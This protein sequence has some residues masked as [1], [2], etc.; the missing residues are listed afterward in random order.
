MLLTTYVSFSIIEKLDKEDIMNYKS[1]ATPVNAV[2]FF[3]NKQHELIDKYVTWYPYTYDVSSQT[4]IRYRLHENWG[5]TEVFDGCWIVEF[6]NGEVHVVLD[7]RFE[8]R[9]QQVETYTP[10]EVT[11]AISMAKTLAV[12]GGEFS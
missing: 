7:E 1:I 9:F 6:P 2:Q 3:E 8:Q 5:S 4:V 11:N 10:E 12:M